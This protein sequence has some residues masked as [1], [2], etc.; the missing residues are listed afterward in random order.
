MLDRPETRRPDFDH[1]CLLPAHAVEDQPTD[2]TRHREGDFLG[3]RWSIGTSHQPIHNPALVGRGLG[4]CQKG[5]GLDVS[6]VAIAVGVLSELHAELA[7]RVGFFCVERRRCTTG[8]DVHDDRV[9][10]VVEIEDHLPV[11]PAKK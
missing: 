6:V 4:R 3:D 5:T 7:E 8:H 2:E 11:R 9:A 1:G 10:V